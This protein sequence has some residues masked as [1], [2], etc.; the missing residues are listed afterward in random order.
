MF[1]IKYH[2]IPY[3]YGISLAKYDIPSD[4]AKCRLFP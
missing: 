3:Y 4:F 2:I 1:P